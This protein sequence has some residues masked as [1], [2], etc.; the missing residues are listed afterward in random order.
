MALGCLTT[1]PRIGQISCQIPYQYISNAD[2]R[3]AEGNREGHVR[4]LWWALRAHAHR[5]RDRG[6]TQQTRP[7]VPQQSRQSTKKATRK[8]LQKQV[9]IS[10]SVYT[11]RAQC[12]KRLLF[13]SPCSLQTSCLNLS[14]LTISLFLHACHPYLHQHGSR[15]PAL[16]LR[17]LSQGHALHSPNTTRDSRAGGSVAM[18][19]CESCCI[20]FVIVM[21]R[22]ETI[23]RKQASKSY[24]YV[25]EGGQTVHFFR[26]FTKSEQ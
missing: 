10:M 26:F 2:D 25:V 13:L 21:L 15:V 11:V 12:P 16:S 23:I 5:Y 9:H 24:T 1:R 18:T 19:L 3:F 4:I 7:T 17:F 20:P 14:A 8:H 6:S 22:T